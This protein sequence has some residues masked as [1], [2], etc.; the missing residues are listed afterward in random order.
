MEVDALVALEPDQPR[1]GSAGERLRDLGLADAGLTLEQQ[2]LLELD[3]EVY[4]GR[5][6]PVREIAL[7]RQGLLYGYGPVEAQTLT[8]SSS[9]LFVSTRARWRL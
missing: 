8:A 9:A 2:R 4:G 5:E 1:A 7:A 6:A 3:R